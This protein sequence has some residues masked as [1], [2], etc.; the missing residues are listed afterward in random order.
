MFDLVVL[1]ESLPLIDSH[2]MFDAK[3]KDVVTK[4]GTDR[5]TFLI[6]PFH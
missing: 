4:M 1:R 2:E 3:S 6:Q 5:K